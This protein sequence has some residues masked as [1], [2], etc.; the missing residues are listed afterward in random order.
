MINKTAFPLLIICCL[1][2][3][4]FSCSNK[5]TSSRKKITLEIQPKKTTYVFGEKVSIHASTDLK[6]EEI[7]GIK[8][9]YNNE[10][11]GQTTESELFLNDFELNSLGNG[12]FKMVIN[13][14]DGTNTSKPLS[15]K[16]L[17]NISPKKYTYQ[18]VNSYP[19]LTSSYTQGLEYYNGYMYEGT[20]EYGESHLYQIDLKSGQP[21]KTFKMDDSYFGEGITILNN[22]IYQLTY[23]AQTAFLYDIENFSVI[24]SFKYTSKEGWG[25]T[26]DGEN[27]IMSNGS[28]NLIWLNPNDFTIVK[29][30]QVANN[31][32]VITNLNELEYIDDIIY[33]NI[34]T[35]NTIIQIDAKT[36]SVLSEIN[37]NGIL[38]LYNNT[39]VDYMNGIA[40]DKENDRLFVTGKWWPRLFEIKLVPLK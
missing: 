20:G 1:F 38:N 36:G 34:Y 7:E 5:S 15:I 39:H 17:S 4:F 40:Y 19:H 13:K 16:T 31:N 18:I 23:F 37:L 24:D 22:K 35:T 33:A 14:T 32:D 26:N 30:L 10:T 8:L 9:L 11:I 29:N 25:L 27:L 28:H 2:V 21:I 3:S 6:P 12:I